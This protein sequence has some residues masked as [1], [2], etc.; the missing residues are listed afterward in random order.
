MRAVFSNVNLNHHFLR[1][2]ITEIGQLDGGPV[3]HDTSETAS[4]P[5]VQT[6]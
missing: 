2:G 4:C 3:S 5:N 6:A 1:N